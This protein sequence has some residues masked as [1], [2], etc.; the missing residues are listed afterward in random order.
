[1][2]KFMIWT[3]KYYQTKY[4]TP[5]QLNDIIVLEYDRPLLNSRGE[6]LTGEDLDWEE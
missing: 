4:L 2:R 5:T 1:M 3:G 6:L